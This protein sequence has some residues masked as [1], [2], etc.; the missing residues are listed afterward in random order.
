MRTPPLPPKVA[1]LLR[2]PPGPFQPSFWRS[3]LRGPWLTSILGMILL[4]G[5]AI[6]FL[7]GLLSYAAYNPRLGGPY[8]DLT[9][10]KGILGFY[11][12]TWPTRPAWLYQL[13]QGLHVLVGIA[14][15]PVLV[16]KLWSVIPKLFAWPPVDSPAQAVERGS[17]LLV[18]GGG[19]FEFA[20][21]IINVQYWYEFPAGFYTAHFYGAWIFLAGLT[22]HVVV[23]FGR[24]M[25]ALRGTR[26]RDVLRTNV[27]DTRAEPADQQGLATP[28]PA[29]ATMSRRGVLAL[30]AGSS[31]LLLLVSAGQTL[32]GPF[33]RLALLVPRGGT[34]GRTTNDFQ[35]NKTA[36]S[37]GVTAAMA[38]P[39]WRLTLNGVRA[40]ELSRDDLLAMPQHTERLPLAC[41]EGW[42]TTQNWT[43]VRLR[44]LAELTGALDTAGTVLVESLQARGAF[45]SV[46][47]A[48][49]Q[50]LDERSLLVLRVNGAD[51]SMDHG[52]PA[53]IIVPNNPGVHNTKWVT[54]MTFER[55]R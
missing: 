41:V 7:T 31:F 1:E 23:R 13:T 45:R 12:F 18:V 8:N 47:L 27:D 17:L 10:G 32:G 16:A 35:V 22:V 25:R 40:V 15:V 2:Q 34:E 38:G 49:N 33:R 44:D 9:P 4:V 46:R 6:V 19:I 36:A 39:S 29:P 55:A 28:N 24:M 42:S 26:L 14:L 5:L 11:L 51:I 54:R 52:F 37:R 50:L 53:R 30:I 3:P 21:G 48:R 43:G 20:T